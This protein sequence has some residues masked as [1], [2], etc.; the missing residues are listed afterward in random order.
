M[1]MQTV[2]MVTAMS[3]CPNLISGRML[4]C[5]ES[6][7]VT[8]FLTLNLYALDTG[9]EHHYPDFHLTGCDDPRESIKIFLASF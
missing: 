6:T 7:D 9:P 1:W 8:V 5:F 3:R 2:R 4:G